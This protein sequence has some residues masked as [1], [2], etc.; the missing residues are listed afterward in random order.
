M[1]YAPKGSKA[2]PP[3]AINLKGHWLKEA[4]LRLASPLPSKS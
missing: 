4:G 2:T 3:P 1:G